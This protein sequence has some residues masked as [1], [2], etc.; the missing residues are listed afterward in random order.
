V[1]ALRF[2]PRVLWLSG[3]PARVRAQLAG[4]VLTREEA[5]PLR[6]EIST[7]EITPLPV[8]VH[9]DATLGRW[10][11]TGFVAGGER[12]AAT[13]SATPGSRWSSRAAATA[14]AAR[15]STASSP[16][17]PPACVW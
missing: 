14:R 9:F 4:R 11:Y 17:A 8:M 15:A 13:R 5:G 2:A 1:T 7:D 10:P 16:S 3:D 12:S 6:D